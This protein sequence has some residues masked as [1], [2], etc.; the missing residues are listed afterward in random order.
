MASRRHAVLP[1]NVRDWLIA[2]SDPAAPRQGPAKKLTASD[3]ALLLEA[4]SHHAVRPAILRN[5]AS[6]IAKDATLIVA[7]H[8]G[9]EAMRRALDAEKDRRIAQARLED[10][11]NE[12]G[13]RIS[14]ALSASGVRSLRTKGDVFAKRLYPNPLD[15]PFGDIDI[16]VPVEHLDKSNP[17]MTELGFRL[18]SSKASGGQKYRIDKWIWPEEK[19]VEVEIQASLIHSEKVG[20]AVSLSYDELLAAGGGN[21]EDAVALLLAGAIHGAA[22][23]QLDRLQHII[24]VLQAVRGVAGEVD[25]ERLKSAAATTGSTVA[26]QATLD[27]AGTIFDEPRAFAL[28]DRLSPAP[29]RGM[30]RRLFTP[31]I[32]LRARSR[33]KRRDSW[34]R[35][36]LQ[37]VIRSS[38]KRERQRNPASSD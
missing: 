15:R 30:R 28:A 33:A 12:Q 19:T 18:D 5:V 34:R 4:S 14:S 10:L 29:W 9:E 6:M 38:G 31:D 26:V 3:I 24:D 23:H 35:K 36:L 7:D 8:E 27:L 1:A 37:A 2:L 11:L 20:S 17:I 22:V 16:L 13:G 32:L 25:A 21:S